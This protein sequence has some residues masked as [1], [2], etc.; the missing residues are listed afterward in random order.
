MPAIE[1]AVARLSHA[2]DLLICDGYGIAHPRR[3]GL[4]SH[5]GLVLDISTIGCAKTCLVGEYESRESKWRD[6]GSIEIEWVCPESDPN[7]KK[8]LE[9]RQRDEYRP[10]RDGG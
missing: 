7:Y 8:Y 5:F 10:A 6:D 9:E 3:F 4:A 1:R 2:P